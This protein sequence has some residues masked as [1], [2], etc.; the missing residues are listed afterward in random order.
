MLQVKY[1][2]KKKKEGEEKGG[3]KKKKRKKEGRRKRRKKKIFIHMDEHKMQSTGRPSTSKPL[4]PF[5][6][7]NGIT[8]LQTHLT[9]CKGHFH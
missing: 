2:K 5:E 7:P 9:F 8:Y 6:S 1:I 4:L 3:E